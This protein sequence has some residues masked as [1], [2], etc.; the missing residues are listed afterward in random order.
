VLLKQFTGQEMM[1]G[2]SNNNMEMQLVLSQVLTLQQ[3]ILTTQQSLSERL[4]SL[5]GNLVSL[6]SNASHQFT[7]LVD[8][9]KSIKSIRLTHERKQIELH[10]ND[11]DFNKSQPYNSQQPQE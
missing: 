5:E 8:Q 1:P 10:G 9:V 3:Q 6:K 4:S 11:N 2:L 7:N